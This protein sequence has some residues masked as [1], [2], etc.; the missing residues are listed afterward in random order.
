MMDIPYNIDL[1]N[2]VQVATSY[3]KWVPQVM[4]LTSEHSGIWELTAMVPPGKNQYC[5]LI[6]DQTICT[7]SDQEIVRRAETWGKI[8]ENKSLRGLPNLVNKI[9]IEIPNEFD[10]DGSLLPRCKGKKI[11][12]GKAVWT[13]GISCF[14]VRKIEREKH[15]AR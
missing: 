15:S 10:A 3:D 12:K 2:T 9:V 14:K 6:N 5:F 11:P 8:D 4:T 7:A 13:F 1:I